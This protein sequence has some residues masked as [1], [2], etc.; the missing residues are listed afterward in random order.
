MSSLAEICIY[1]TYR[2]TRVAVAG[3]RQSGKDIHPASPPSPPAAQR[4]TIRALG[5]KKKLHYTT[6]QRNN[7]PIPPVVIWDALV[8]AVSE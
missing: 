7:Q 4:S 3:A 2:R 5:G 6:S 8:W 1:S